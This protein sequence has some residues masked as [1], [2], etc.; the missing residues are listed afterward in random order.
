MF[1]DKLTAQEKKSLV[2]LLTFIARSDGKIAEQEWRFLNRF[3]D[4]NGLTYDINE[5]NNLEHICGSIQSY[6]AK[7]VAMQ[8]VIKMALTD[9]EYPIT[10]KQ[11]AMAIAQLLGFDTKQFEYIENWALEGYAWAKKGEAMVERGVGFE[12]VRL[13][14]NE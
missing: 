12:P 7:V 6:P 11:N 10:E 1:V 3:C 13:A 14:S 5:E 4:R 2:Q 9:G 8:Q